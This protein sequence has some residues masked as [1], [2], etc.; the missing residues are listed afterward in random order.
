MKYSIE[1]N[2]GD[3]Y[4]IDSNLPLNLYDVVII[5]E[6]IK[7]LLLFKEYKDHFVAIEVEE[8]K[9]VRLT[10]SGEIT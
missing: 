5:Q 10:G 2:Q 9:N 3:Y 7:S 1:T 8:Y 6:N 4:S